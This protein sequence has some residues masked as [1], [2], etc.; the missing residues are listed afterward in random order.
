MQVRHA[1]L[2]FLSRFNTLMAKAVAVTVGLTLS[3]L[4]AMVAFDYSAQR[5]LLHDELASRAQDVTG[6]LAKQMG[7]SIKFRNDVA[8][9]E[10][11]RGVI[12]AARPEALGALVVA[13]NSDVLFESEGFNARLQ[14]ALALS[15][16]A[17]T[18]GTTVRSGD[19]LMVAAPSFFGAD[20]TV[21]GVVATAWDDAQIMALLARNQLQAI[22]VAAIVFVV[23]IV[24]M[25][26]FA[27]WH[28]S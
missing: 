8:V 25:V 9:A 11:T 2:S 20:N 3:V 22:G 23:T 7:G 24:L 17:F 16:S 4:V 21:A 13:G 1:F 5:A 15:Q 28:V 10:I 14:E 27:F 18:K 12:D 6:L 26:T 19:G